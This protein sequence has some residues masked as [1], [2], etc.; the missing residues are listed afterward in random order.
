MSSN[1]WCSE[2]F[3]SLFWKHTPNT[4]PAT[5]QACCNSSSLNIRNHFSSISRR[6]PDRKAVEARCNSLFNL[7][8]LSLSDMVIW[9]ATICVVE[10]ENYVH[11]Q[12]DLL[13][14]WSTK[15]VPLWNT[16]P[17]LPK[18]NYTHPSDSIPFW[19]C[20]SIRPSALVPAHFVF[21]CHGCCRNTKLQATKHT[22]FRKNIE[23]Y[24]WNPHLFKCL[25]SS[26][27]GSWWFLETKGFL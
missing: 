18:A 6:K 2:F 13:N 11:L 5:S 10:H 15:Y 3:P 21:R 19:T 16:S 23:L 25:S 24:I 8:S 20:Y 26:N 14:I 7:K 12:G 1:K 17:D 22:S 27:T 9:Y 4:Q